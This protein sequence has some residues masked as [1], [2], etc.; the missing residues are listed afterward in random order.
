M[1]RLKVTD[2]DLDSL[3]EEELAGM[4]ELQA[5]EEA[6][7][8]AAAEEDGEGEGAD[9]RQQDD[10]QKTEAASKKAE[11]PE[12]T[13]KKDEKVEKDEKADAEDAGEGE[14][15]GEEGDEG[16]DEAEDDEGEGEAEG[17]EEGD[18]GEG[19]GEKKPEVA[20]RS[21]PY[22]ITAQEL[23]RLGAVEKEID[24]I[25]E[26]FDD[27]EL[28]AKEM[29]DQQR[30]LLHELDELKEKRTIAKMHGA[31]A[32]SRWYGQTIPAFLADHTEY[33]KGSL[34]FKLLDQTVKE[35]QAASND[36]TDPQ[37][38]VDAHAKINEEFGAVAGA[39][40]AKKAAKKPVGNGRTIPPTLS[41][42]PAADISDTSIKSE[43]GHLEKLKGVAYERAVSKLAPDA[44]ERYLMGG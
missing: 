9:D 7:R 42:V 2:D 27:G 44:R 38:L 25:A 35:L 16:E 15:E 31:D 41:G 11:K 33:K 34:R 30:E 32:S 4:R 17:D 12:K 18:E 6:E 43:F 8:L 3:T 5:E 28:T 26:K 37:I 24:A 36:P 13:D 39:E 20:A 10:G 40:P 22:Q 14:G 1:A 29:R 21:L 23:A 19:D